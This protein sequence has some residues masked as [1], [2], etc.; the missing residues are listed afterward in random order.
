MERTVFFFVRERTAGQKSQGLAV[1]ATTRPP[2]LTLTETS[3][4]FCACQNSGPRLE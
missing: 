1:N 3:F 2:G 4:Y